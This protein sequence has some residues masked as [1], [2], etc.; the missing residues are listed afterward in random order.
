MKFVV[1]NGTYHKVQSSN[2]KVQRIKIIS[3]ISEIRSW[4]DFT[5]MIRK[6]RNMYLN[7][8]YILV[9]ERVGERVKNVLFWSLCKCFIIN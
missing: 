3:A 5:I 6:I 9:D 4:Y 7:F 1:I 8:F 2:L